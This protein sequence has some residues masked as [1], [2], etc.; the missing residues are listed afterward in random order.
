M[1]TA[2]LSLLVL[3]A[4]QV[5]SSVAQ[6]WSDAGH[7][8][9]ALIAWAKLTP[10]VREK[11]VKL[12]EDHPEFANHFAAPLAAELGTTPS[13]EERQRW[14]FAQAAIWSDLVRPP[15]DGSDNPNQKYH[16]ASWHYMDLPVY[17]DAEA[18]KELASKM[19]TLYWKWKPGLPDFIE[20]KIT[21]AQV[22]DK[23]KQ[24]VPD[25]EKHINYERSVMLC[26]AFHVTGDLHQPCHCSSLFSMKQFPK[27]DR[28]G[29]SILLKNTTA[30]NLHSFWDEQLGNKAALSDAQKMADS[31]MGD[32]AIMQKA[33][34]ASAVLDPK[35]WITEGSQLAKAAVYPP[36]ILAAV[37][38]SEIHTYDKN[39]IR[40]EAVGPLDLTAE[41]MQ[42]YSK[43]AL[44]TA[45][46]QA[47]IGGFR[48]ARL[49]ETLVKT[50]PAQ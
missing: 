32:S 19:H 9:V 34:A 7:K 1:R 6:A 50:K 37:L 43:N 4:L 33:E 23:A 44:A 29:N 26:W 30:P 20:M 3:A 15:L 48:L 36:D 40:Y 17:A 38:K 11:V 18:E 39:H 24:I 28:G 22:I 2:S 42:T 5:F 12:L 14:L 25:F 8:T 27:G 41:Q 45:R 46:Q 35:T 21:A 10:E 31:I 13:V 16:H 47:A 49:L